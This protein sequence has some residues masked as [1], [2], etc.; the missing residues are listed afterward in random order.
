MSEWN[1]PFVEYWDQA[2][3]AINRNALRF[4]KLAESE[5]AV[6]CKVIQDSVQRSAGGWSDQQLLRAA[7]SM[8]DDLYMYMNDTM[9][10]NA[11]VYVYLDAFA[12]TFTMTVA[13]RGYVVEYIAENA[14]SGIDF[15]VIGPF[16]WFSKVF[17]AAGFVYICPQHLAFRLM[18]AD[19]LAVSD[20]E[21]SVGKYIAEAR[22]LARRLVMECRSDKRH[23]VFLEA[24]YEDDS[25]NYV[26]EGRGDS[27]VLSV[28]RN[29]AP[30]L[31]TE[32]DVVF[33]NS[34]IKA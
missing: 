19:G 14:F 15:L 9:L 11:A 28:F 13:E 29:Q 26:L 10:S 22:M 21:H 17:S 31:G 1:T 12:R 34:K 24:D 33:P 3:G 27:G 4:T 6:A 5:R 25:L 18:Q 16:D 2:T 7:V 32:V 8:V 23:F 20:Y 30:L